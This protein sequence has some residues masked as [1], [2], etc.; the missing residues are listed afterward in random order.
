M[1][2]RTSL[3]GGVAVLAIAGVVAVFWLRSGPDPSAFA[4]LTAPRLTHLDAQRMLVVEATGDPNVVTGGA[5]KLLFGTY[6]KANGV[7]RTQSP[8][9][10]RARWPRSLDT[11]GIEW[12]GRYAVPIGEQVTAVPAVSAPGGL[13]VSLET[14]EYGDV[15]E[16]VHIGPYNKE[17]EDITRL[18]NFVALSGYRVIGDHEEQYVRGPGMILA[19]DP[20]KYITIIRLRVVPLQQDEDVDEG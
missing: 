1:T 9:A 5:I 6:Y 4:Y 2:K 14:W 15:A 18:Q 20:Q 7:S 10:P 8:P 17:E 13:R 11:P 12:V 16:I 19:G 3:F